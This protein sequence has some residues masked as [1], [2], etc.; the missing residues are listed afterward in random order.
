MR[1]DEIL[2]SG[3]PAF[4]FEFF[5]PK[6]QAG[7]LKLY[8]ALRAGPLDPSFVSVTYGAGGST[9]AKTIEI[10]KRI[11]ES[12][13]WRRWPTSLCR[14][15]RTRSCAARFE[16]MREPR[17]SR[18][19]SP[20]AATRPPA[21]RN[22]SRPREASST[23]ASSVE[24][25]KADYSFAIGAA[26]FPRPTS[27]QRAPRRSGAPG[28]KGRRRSRL[29][30]HPVVLRQRALLRFVSRARE[31][32]VKV[33]IIPGIM[34]ITHMGQLERMA[35]MRCLDPGGPGPRAGPRERGPGGGAGL[36]RRLRHAPVRRAAGRRRP[37]RST[38]T[39]STARPPRGRSCR[40]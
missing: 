38:S 23:R 18:T 37:R 39:R 5:P 31:A 8:E 40:R 25:I 30:D 26:C 17:T 15:H 3:E 24:L 28:R 4:S 13:G 29:P 7:E 11:K 36:R 22:G 10:V 33:P 2:A 27:T 14:R 21:R 12:T 32:G 35:S 20:Y 34:P 16:E 19:C 9:R 6:T 1:I